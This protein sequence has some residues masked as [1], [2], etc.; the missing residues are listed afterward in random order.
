MTFLIYVDGTCIGQQEASS[1]DEAL[2]LFCERFGWDCQDGMYA[3]PL[4]DTRIKAAGKPDALA[5]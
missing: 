3:E 5:G 4:T 2:D 1:E